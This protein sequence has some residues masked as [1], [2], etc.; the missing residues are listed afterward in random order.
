MLEA[1]PNGVILGPGEKVAAR[2]KRFRAWYTSLQKDIG[3]KGVVR[4]ERSPLDTY[5]KGTGMKGSVYQHA[6]ATDLAFRNMVQDKKRPY[7]IDYAYILDK[8]REANLKII[9]DEQKRKLAA[10]IKL[11]EEKRKQAAQIK[12]DEQKRKLAAKIKLDEEKRTLAANIQLGE[13]KRKLTA[14]KRK[15]VSRKQVGNVQLG[16]QECKLAAKKRKLGKKD[17]TDGKETKKMTIH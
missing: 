7:V 17:A 9:V 4:L 12:L 2:S 14:K 10:K 13:Q 6:P 16:E 15:P 8:L 1:F 5:I 3:D 11:Q